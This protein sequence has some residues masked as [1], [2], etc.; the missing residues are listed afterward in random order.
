MPRTAPEELLCIH[1][2]ILDDLGPFR[3]WRDHYPSNGL[4]G[5][6]TNVPLDA[7][8]ATQPGPSWVDS[9]VEPSASRQRPV[10]EQGDCCVAS[11]P[12]LCKAVDRQCQFSG[13]HG[14]QQDIPPIL[15]QVYL[16]DLLQKECEASPSA[17]LGSTA[18]GVHCVVLCILVG[19]ISFGTIAR[20]K[21]S[22]TR[23]T[24]GLLPLS[25][26]TPAP[27]KRVICIRRNSSTWALTSA[28]GP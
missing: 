20:Q 26:R 11:L 7:E 8:R 25:V 24:P 15:H 2:R 10:S 1:R 17:F 22:F 21:S 13:G 6:Q 16:D 5:P 14:T 12:K 28:V 9:L 3:V 19:G 4:W 23:D 18:P 27:C